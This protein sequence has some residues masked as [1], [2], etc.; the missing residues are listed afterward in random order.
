MIPAGRDRVVRLLA[1]LLAAGIALLAPAAILSWHLGNGLRRDL[2]AQAASVRVFAG[3]VGIATGRIWRLQFRAS[4]LR[5]EDATV[6][7]L[8]GTLRDVT[9]DVRAALAGRLRILG[10]AGGTMAVVVDEGDL[11]RYLAGARDIRN[12]R[13]RLDD[14]RVTITGAV[15][16]L[17]ASF[18]IEVTARLAIDGEAL[19]LRVE[20]LQISGVP[21]PQDLGNVLMGAVN[22]LLHAPQEPVPMR[23][24]GVR[25]DDGRAVISGVV[26]P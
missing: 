6:R 3:P 16:V 21:I 25:V 8:R 22:P 19:V 13:V 24:S 20:R 18:P 5:V 14:G 2:R 4:R 15:L 26:R 1:L 11:Q 7:Q 10:M 17:N 12:A 23:F 9:I